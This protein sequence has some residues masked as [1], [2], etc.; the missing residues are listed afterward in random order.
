MC[1]KYIFKGIYNFTPKIHLTG[2]P[3]YFKFL[4]ILKEN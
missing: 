4:L 2:L 3:L 1:V